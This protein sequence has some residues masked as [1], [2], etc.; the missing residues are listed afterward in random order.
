MVS[1][2]SKKVSVKRDI[3][4]IVIDLKGVKWMNSLGIGSIMRSHTTIKNAGGELVL[5]R[6]SDKVNSVLILTQLIKIFKTF[7]NIEDALK[8]F[9]E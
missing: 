8:S 9:A 3:K 7:N 1:K 2:K 5:A 4:K 6:L